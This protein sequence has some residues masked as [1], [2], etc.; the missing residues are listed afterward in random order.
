MTRAKV[1][2]YANGQ[3]AA[4]DATALRD[5]GI[6]SRAVAAVWS[7][8]GQ[9]SA[10]SPWCQDTGDRLVTEFGTIKVT[11]WLAKASSRPSSDWSAEIV[12]ML[13]CDNAAPDL[14]AKIETVL[15]SGG[16]IVAVRSHDEV[17]T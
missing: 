14:R 1:D 3:D 5:V 9:N 6:G 13:D 11:G 10:A 17:A 16:G 12:R 15:R 8:A 4:D 7:C 2:F